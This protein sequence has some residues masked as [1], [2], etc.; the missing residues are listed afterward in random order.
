[1]HAAPLYS[2][3]NKFEPMISN[4]RKQVREI[5]EKVVDLGREIQDESPDTKVTISSIIERSDDSLNVKIREVNK[6]IAKFAKQNHWSL[7][8][9][10]NIT[11]EQ[12]N[13]SG[14]HLNPEGTKILASNFISHI[15]KI[16]SRQ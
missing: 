12:L 2:E 8:S 11:K 10:A 13:S 16:Y 6:T 4:S 5:A 3:D 15:K 1:M 7:L 9:N 14:L